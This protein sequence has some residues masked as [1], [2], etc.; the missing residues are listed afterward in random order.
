MEFQ[1]LLPRQ[2]PDLEAVRNVLSAQDPAALADFDPLNPL[3][4]VSASLTARDLLALLRQAGCAVD[5]GAI[6]A[7]PSNCCGGCGG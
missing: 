7:L 5:E 4:R 1:V 6:R 2:R 3:L